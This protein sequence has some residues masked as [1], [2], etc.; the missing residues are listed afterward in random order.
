MMERPNRDEY[1]DYY[2]VYV[3]LVPAGDLEAILRSQENETLDIYRPLS[4]E[5]ARYRY[6]P[7]KWSLKEML[8]HLTDTE[9][10]MSYRLLRISRGDMSPLAGFDQD[11]FVQE[12]GFDNLPLALLLEDYQAVRASTL[13]LLRTLDARK[14]ARKGVANGSEVSVRALACVIAGHEAHH[15]NVIRERYKQA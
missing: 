1:N 15:L 13:T 14:L 10:V 9:R 11:E 5:Q 6:A 2:A 7:D 8:G 3:G 4:E 12:S